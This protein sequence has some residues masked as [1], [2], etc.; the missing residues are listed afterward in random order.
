MTHM[1]DR[2]KAFT[3]VFTLSLYVRDADKLKLCRLLEK[4]IANMTVQVKER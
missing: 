4:V 1:F 3:S 2:Y